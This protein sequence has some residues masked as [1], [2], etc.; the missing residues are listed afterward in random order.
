M[1][2]DRK[3]ELKEIFKGETGRSERDSDTEEK[4]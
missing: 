3:K 1:D 2:R 4:R